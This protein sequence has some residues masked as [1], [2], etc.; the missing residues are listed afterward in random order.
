MM[1]D[2]LESASPAD[3]SFWPIHPALERIWQWK[4]IV[5]FTSEA[6]TSS[7]NEC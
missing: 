6:W 4:R 1:G 7:A 3:P 2:Q 5:G